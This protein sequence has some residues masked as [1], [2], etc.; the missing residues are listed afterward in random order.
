MR[1]MRHHII[2]MTYSTLSTESN[3]TQGL[4]LFFVI[5]L[6]FPAAIDVYGS[7]AVF[8]ICSQCLEAKDV[9]GSPPLLANCSQCLEAKDV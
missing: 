8:V 4:L 5:C 9:L 6:Q 1:W 3:V 2:M 7:P